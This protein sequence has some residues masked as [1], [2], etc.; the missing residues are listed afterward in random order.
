[1]PVASGDVAALLPLLCGQSQLG[2]YGVPPSLSPRGLIA[3]AG[4]P[5]D[6]TGTA[7]Q[8]EG[9]RCERLMPNWLAQFQS[10]Q[11]I[12]L[13]GRGS[14]GIFAKR[15]S[16]VK[17]LG[18]LSPL[19]PPRSRIVSTNWTGR[20]TK[21]CSERMRWVREELNL[22]PLP[23]QQTTGNRCARRRSR[24]SRSTVAAEVTCSLWR[25]VKWCLFQ[26]LSM[27]PRTITAHH[28]PASMR[29]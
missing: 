24:R 6:S 27:T 10:R 21:P 29:R 19:G 25:S 9:D 20:S 18:A 2:R 12:R 4:V 16:S 15:T 3:L 26:R 28:L 1:M 5:A 22:R 7:P 17:Q 8:A 11:F 13:D 14:L 23:C